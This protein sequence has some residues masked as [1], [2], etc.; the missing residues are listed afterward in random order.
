[1][2]L[3]FCSSW[4]EVVAATTLI[5]SEKNCVAAVGIRT[6]LGETVVSWDQ[7]MSAATIF[8]IPPIILFLFIQ[9]YLVAGLTAGAV[10]G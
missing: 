8:T 5:N 4:D 3:S 10:K 7:I 1:M 6:F 9:K 2:L